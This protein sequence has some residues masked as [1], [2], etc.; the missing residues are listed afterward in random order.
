MQHY[1]KKNFSPLLALSFLLA[2]VAFPIVFTENLRGESRPDSHSPIGVM[3]DHAHHAGEIM[4]SYRYMFMNMDQNYDGADTISVDDIIAP[5]GDFA[6]SPTEMSM[7]MHMLGIMFAPFD[8]LTIMTMLPFLQNS[9]SHRVAPPVASNPNVGLNSFDTNSSGVGDLT[10]A[11]LVPL[12]ISSD[13]THLLQTHSLLPSLGLSFPT[14]SIDES[15]E[16]PVPP[17]KEE[18]I[19]PYPMQIGSGTFDL[20]PALTYT[21]KA[22]D[23]SIGLQTKGTIRLNRNKEDYRLGNRILATTWLSYLFASWIS[24][25]F[26]VEWQSWGNIDGADSRIAQEPPS[27]PPK[28]VPTAQPD[29]RGGER[30]DLLLGANLYTQ[31]GPGE[32]QRLAFEL[33]YTVYQE[34]NGP[35]LGNQFLITVGWQSLL[36]DLY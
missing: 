18:R 31:R 2:L 29:L 1:L 20:L 4:F 16:L 24:G 3:G 35:Q 17:P 7:Q 26:R 10:V 6:V 15:G 27:G 21:F 8:K 22:P 32:D 23:F 14:G 9:M 12:A 33:G 11:F 36:L 28:S 5:N 34:L 19:L 13:E 25:S 30:L